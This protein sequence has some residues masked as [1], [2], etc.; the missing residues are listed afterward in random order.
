MEGNLNWLGDFDE[1]LSVSNPIPLGSNYSLPNDVF[2]TR[3]CTVDI[4]TAIVSY[5]PWEF[6]GVHVISNDE[7]PGLNLHGA[8]LQLN[9]PV[10]IKMAAC[11]PKGCQGGDVALFYRLFVEQIFPGAKVSATCKIRRDERVF[12]ARNMVAL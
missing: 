12:Y 1:C 5:S 6:K 9:M 3:Y 2:D 11:V 7:A 10:S 4:S 8:L